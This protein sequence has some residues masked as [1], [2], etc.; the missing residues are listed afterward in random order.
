MP[1]DGKGRWVCSSKGVF[2]QLPAT[3]C[4]GCFCCWPFRDVTDQQTTGLAHNDNSPT[5]GEAEQVI[6]KAKAL[7]KATI[8][9]LQPTSFSFT[10]QQHKI[11]FSPHSLQIHFSSPWEQTFQHFH[12]LIRCHQVAKAQILVE[13]HRLRDHRW[14]FTPN[15][16]QV[17]SAYVVCICLIHKWFSLGIV[18]FKKLNK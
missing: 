8:Y 2:Q 11:F 18:F 6:T 17:H 12:L 1:K 4:P 16:Y 9:G 5:P 3:I 7:L 10:S 14:P 15:S 13:Q